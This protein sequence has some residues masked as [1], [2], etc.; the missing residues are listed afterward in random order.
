MTLD[1]SDTA[2]PEEQVRSAVIGA[3]KNRIIEID[4]KLDDLNQNLEYFQRKYN[5]ES[6]NFYQQFCSG[7]LGD[8][9]DFLEWKSSWEIYQELILEKKALLEA[10]G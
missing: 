8:E 9:M 3:L 6:E 7:S 2:M 1:V 5:L 10:L 4:I